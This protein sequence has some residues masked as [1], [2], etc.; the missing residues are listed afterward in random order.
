MGFSMF[1]KAHDDGGAGGAPRR[2]PRIAVALGAGVARGWAHIGVLDEL[3]RA[4][5]TPEIVVGTS[6]GAV[7]GGAYAAGKL[8]EMEQ[9]ARSVTMRRMFGM[10]DF[11]FGGGLFGGKRLEARLAQ[12]LSGMDVEHL[13]KKFA[14]VAT[15]V[16]TG[17]EIWL[18][19]G[20]LVTAIRASYALPGVF[21][22]VRAGGRWLFDGALVN[23]V[24]ITAARA[25]GADMVIAVNLNAD[26]VGRGTV[27]QDHVRA[28]EHAGHAPSPYPVDPDA[29]LRTKMIAGDGAASLGL[30]TVMVDAFNITQDR[31]TRSRLAGDPPDVMI[32]ARLGRI[33]LFEFHR[34]DEAIALGREAA[35]RSVDDIKEHYAALQRV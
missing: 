3:D 1:R 7:V 22:P 15:E 14:A 30:A 19:K 11:S 8:V 33:G 9:F 27:I 34:A 23:P 4:G 6:I 12:S 26:S 21:E 28:Q 13:P 32:Q 10:L 20:D 5:L 25:L 16:G 18:T 24:P 17:H 31:I 35:R 2:K 29:S